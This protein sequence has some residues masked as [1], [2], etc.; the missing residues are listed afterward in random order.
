MSNIVWAI[1]PIALMIIFYILIFTGKG[2]FTRVRKSWRRYDW[3]TFLSAIFGCI[4][5]SSTIRASG[6]QFPAVPLLIATTLIIVVVLTI[7]LV[8]RARTGRPVVQTMGDER[9]GVILAKSARNG[10]FATYIALFVHLFV[11]DAGTMDS[12]WLLIMLTTGLVVLIASLPI[13]YY[14]KT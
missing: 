7:A 11:T 13:Y 5:L 9:T 8:R 12:N 3:I 2:E 10:F 1:L 4:V 14:R 6:I